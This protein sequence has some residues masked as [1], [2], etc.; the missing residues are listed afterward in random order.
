MRWKIP[1]GALLALAL[2]VPSAPAA[3]RSAAAANQTFC[4]VATYTDLRAL[5][6]IDLDTASDTEVDLLANQLQSAAKADKL[7]TLPGR[8][9]TGL[10]GSAED[11]RAFL[12][13]GL[14]SSWYTDLRVATAQSLTDATPH[15]DEAAQAA[16]DAETR[17]ALFTYLNHGRYIAYALDSGSLKE[18]TDFRAR[19]TFDLDT[20]TD[21]QVL[22]LANQLHS[23][24]KK[25]RLTTLPGLLQE[26]LDGT[27]EDLRAFLK[28]DLWTS[29]YID[30]RVATGR[31]LRS[32]G[33][34]AHEAAQVALGAETTDALFTYLN[35]G[36]YVA[37]AL[38]S[39]T[40]SPSA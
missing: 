3:A 20:A 14:W 33:P 39:C 34:L 35:H 7:T 28:T 17:D 30:L 12:R 8:L 6:T 29:W 37:R 10:D 19:V 36:L 32:A 18:F 40:A 21:L 15:V 22:L 5:V 2:L 13:T 23:A 11:L 27:V 9:Q 1:A 4:R 24:S 25:D 16:L 38:E 26:R 31:T